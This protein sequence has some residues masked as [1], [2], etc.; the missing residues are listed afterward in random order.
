MPKRLH[1]IILALTLTVLGLVLFFYKL[2]MGVPLSEKASADVWTVET[3]V[4]FAPDPT[5]PIKVTLQL[6]RDIPGYAILNENF[7]SRGYGLST[8]N[9]G[10]RAAQWTI[11]RAF[12]TVH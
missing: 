5:Q 2:Q 12:G 3:R 9:E 10:D 6:P 1:T 11:R 8:T 7:V 4:T